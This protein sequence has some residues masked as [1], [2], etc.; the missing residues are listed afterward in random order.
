FDLFS[1][2]CMS[3]IIQQYTYVV[4]NII[5]YCNNI[6]DYISR[7]KTL[8]KWVLLLVLREIGR[9]ELPFYLRFIKNHVVI[10]GL[11]RKGLLLAKGFLER[12]YCVVVIEN[13]PNNS[14][15]EGCK[16]YGA[17]LLIGNAANRDI[18]RSAHVQKALYLIS[19]CGDDGVNA[20]VAVHTYA[21]VGDR[22]GRVLTCFVHIV[23]YRLCSLLRERE[24]ETEKVDVF[25][26]NSLI[27]ST[28]GQ[29]RF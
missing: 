24:I 16:D 13:D 28:A 4:K 18:L 14:L 23:D 27:F 11:G 10:C 17:I 26:R 29:R 7:G 21:L 20:E 2:I 1:T 22:K 15:I 25:R 3:T 9:G 8:S 19:V 6:S 12:N 5:G